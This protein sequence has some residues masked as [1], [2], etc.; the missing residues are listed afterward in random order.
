MFQKT[1]LLGQLT[2]NTMNTI[3]LFLGLQGLGEGVVFPF[4]I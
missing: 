4:T 2:G 3:S 1:L